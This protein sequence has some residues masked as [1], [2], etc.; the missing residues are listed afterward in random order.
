MTAWDSS[1]YS[2]KHQPESLGSVTATR[3]LTVTTLDEMN[4]R[5][6]RAVYVP[7]RPKPSLRGRG[8]RVVLEKGRWVVKRGSE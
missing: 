5:I 8:P 1:K 3:A 4:R 6:P 7:P 2:I